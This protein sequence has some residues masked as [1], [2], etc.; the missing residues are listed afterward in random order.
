MNKYEITR[1]EL[2]TPNTYLMDIYAPRIAQKSLAGQFIILRATADGERIPL[3]TAD[4]DREKGL[5]TIIF[6]MVGYSTNLLGT[7]NVGDCLHDFVGPLGKPSELDHIKKVICIGGGVGTAVVYPAVKKLYENGAH[8]DVIVGARSKEYVI[9][10]DEIKNNSTNLYITTDDG[11]YGRKG[12]VTDQLKD[13][14][15]KSNDYDEVIA[16][17]PMIM[18]KFVCQLTEKYNVKTMVSL[19]PLMV[20]GTGMCGGC[21]VT[22]GGEIKY[23]CID[24]PDFNGHEVNFDELMKRQM[25]YSEEEKEKEHKC[26]GIY[27]D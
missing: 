5:V 22:I 7:F 3:T 23:A 18:M 25:T 11:S 17:G 13:L 16:I 19:N 15:E 14:L 2:I 26:G 1:K 24:G 8:V 6:Q 4:V 12:F 20:D 10:E 27:H 9:L 21:R